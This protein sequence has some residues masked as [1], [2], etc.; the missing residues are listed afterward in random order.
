MDRSAISDQIDRILRSQSFASKSQLRKLLE[1]LFSNMDSQTTLKPDRVIKELWPNESKTKGSAD[2]AAEMNRLRRALESYYNGEGK[3]DLITISLPNRSVPA[4]DGTQ[5]K[6]WIVAKPRGASEDRPPVPAVNSRRGL[7][8]AAAAAVAVLCMCMVGYVSFRMLAVHDQPQ[9]GRLDGSTLT[10][11][12]A[13]GKELWSKSFPEGFSPDWYYAQ[14]IATRIWFG[15]LDGDGHTSVLFLYLPAVSPM[16]HSTTL[17]CY[18]DR[19][20]EKWRW[21]PGRELPELHGTPATYRMVA[22]GVLKATKKTPPRIVVSS[23]HDPWWPNQIAMLDSNG[24]TIS[25]YWHSGHL[26]HLTLADLDG[27]GRQEIVATGISNGYHQATLVVLD[28]DRLFGASTEAA[29][30]ELQI[31]GM[32]AAEER[33]RLLFPR[34]DLNKALFEYNAGAETTAEHGSIRL[35]VQECLQPPGC[36]IWY[37]FDNHFHLVTAYADQQFRSSHAQFYAKGKD[38]HPFSSEEQAEFQEIRCLAGCKSEFVA[39]QTP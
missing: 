33:L 8:I 24:K 27:D 30:P 2:V 36:P 15:D 25:E 32:G 12:N 4:P 29:R 35:S 31:H 26:D 7:K 34:S 10:I 13:E 14:G 18:S 37:E 16:S 38:A 22:L 5:E 3:A 1:V 9:S 39:L 17:I 11:L 23:I 21:T 20:K 19:G 6:R 28:P